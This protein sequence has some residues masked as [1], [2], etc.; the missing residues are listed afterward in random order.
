MDL[1]KGL[2]VYFDKIPVYWKAVAFLVTI[3][4]G[5]IT[6]GAYKAKK[7]KSVQACMIT[8]LCGYFVLVII[9][10]VFARERTADY[11]YSFD[12]FWSYRKV[13][14]GE[15]Y[16]LN[17]IVYNIFMLAPVGFMLPLALNRMGAVNIF[18]GCSTSLL[19][20]LLQFV[21]KRGIFEMDDI[22]HNSI[23]VIIGYLLL[24]LVKGLRKKYSKIISVD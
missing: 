24:F 2:W 14:T 12:I 23:G 6:Y 9:S 7:I 3:A 11:Q 5:V 1:L 20:E 13:M 16:F 17:Q 10:T 15:N 4:V 18:I 19:I 8:V 21:L 22:L